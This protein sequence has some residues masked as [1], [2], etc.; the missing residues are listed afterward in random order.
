MKAERKKSYTFRLGTHINNQ[1]TA[2]AS[3]YHMDRTAML[4]YMITVWGSMWLENEKKVLD[5]NGDTEA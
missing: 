5:G 1:L 4:E 3:N 2:L